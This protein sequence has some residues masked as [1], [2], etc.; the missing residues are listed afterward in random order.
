MKAP[1]MPLPALVSLPLI[2]PTRPTM[3]VA[4][5]ANGEFHKLG[6][7][8]PQQAHSHDALRRF[9]RRRTE[10]PRLRFINSPV[11]EK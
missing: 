6:S 3:L 1:E 7:H 2:E 10:S 8:P 11:Q 4:F 9:R 5:P